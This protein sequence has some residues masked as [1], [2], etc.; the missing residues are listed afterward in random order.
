M[1]AGLCE[2][3]RQTIEKRQALAPSKEHDDLVRFAL[4]GLSCMCAA[5]GKLK[6][7][8]ELKVNGLK[9]N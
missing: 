9:F 5:T 4:S 1:A 8:K 6:T 7:L 3:R 2:K